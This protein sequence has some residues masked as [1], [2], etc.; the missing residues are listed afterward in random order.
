MTLEEVV[1]DVI[2][3]AL[4]PYKEHDKEVMMAADLRLAAALER[5]RVTRPTNT[6]DGRVDC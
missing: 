3:E 6:L 2:A 1:Q 4:K 5:V